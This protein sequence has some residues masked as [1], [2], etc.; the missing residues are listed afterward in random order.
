MADSKGISGEFEY[1]LCRILG[2]E[3]PP[4]DILGSKFEV[5]K[6]IF[7]N[8]FVAP[9]VTRLWVFNRILDSDYLDQIKKPVL[10]AGETY[11]ELGIDWRQYLSSY[12]E[13]D[14]LNALIGINHA[15]NE[16]FRK[17]R[18][19]GQFSILLD[20]D[21][22]FTEAAWD[23]AILELSKDQKAHPERQFYAVPSVRITR[24]DLTCQELTQ[25]PTEE[26]MLIARYDAIDL[27]DESIPFGRGEKVEFMRRLGL[28]TEGNRY[29]ALS[30]EGKCAVIGRVFHLSIGNEAIEKDGRLRAVRRQDALAELISKADKHGSDLAW[31]EGISSY[32]LFSAKSLL[33]KILLL[34]E[35]KIRQYWFLFRNLLRHNLLRCLRNRGSADKQ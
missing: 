19:M 27:F 22:F 2:N 14:S 20:G 4:R 11:I 10:D 13:C 6:Y 30:S 16:A 33:R 9:G 5:F 8:E 18:Q 25:R 35:K 12:R 23:A 1:V 3:L 29:Y 34:P 17:A 21:C 7:E 32:F 24:E 28:V 31:N 26:P 15:R